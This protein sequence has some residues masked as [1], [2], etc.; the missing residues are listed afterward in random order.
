[1]AGTLRITM[2]RSAIGTKPKQRGTLRALGLRRINHTV[3]HADRPE[4]YHGLP[5]DPHIPTGVS[6]WKRILRP[7]GV[8]AIFAAIAGSFAHY[9]SYGPKQPKEPSEETKS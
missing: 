7:V 4:I 9:L 2:V 8:F 3:E 1:M 5:K 6:V